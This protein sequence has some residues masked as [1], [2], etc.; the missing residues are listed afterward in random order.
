MMN[1]RDILYKV[2]IKAVH[3]STDLLISGIVSDSRQ[4]TENSCFVA[5]SGTTIDG[6]DHIYSAISAGAQVIV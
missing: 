3:G 4:V 6:H 1:L 5:I 2:Q